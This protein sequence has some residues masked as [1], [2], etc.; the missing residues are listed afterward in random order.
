MAIHFPAGGEAMVADGA[1][2]THQ[3]LAVRA[4]SESE[5]LAGDE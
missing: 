5:I 4:D 2:T 1:S 3:S